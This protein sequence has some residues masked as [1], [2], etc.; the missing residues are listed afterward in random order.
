MGTRDALS[1][2]AEGNSSAP[3]FG[4]IGRHFPVGS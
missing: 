4:C 2:R 1:I 3:V